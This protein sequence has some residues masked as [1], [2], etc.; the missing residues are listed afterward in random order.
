MNIS[1]EI[2]ALFI[3]MLLGGA[4]AALAVRGAHMDDTGYIYWQICDGHNYEISMLD[5]DDDDLLERVLHCF[6]EDNIEVIK[7]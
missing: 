7:K 1:S 3:G 5:I 6:R 2:I 4:I